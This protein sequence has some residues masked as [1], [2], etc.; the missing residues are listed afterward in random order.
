[1]ARPGL[2]DDQLNI[3]RAAIGKGDSTYRAAEQAGCSESAARKAAKTHGFVKNALKTLVH[4]ELDTIIIE[5]EVKERKSAI[6][7]TKNALSAH[8]RDV[9]DRLFLEE[10]QARNLTFNVA[11]E[12][13]IGLYDMLKSGT[14]D[15][16]VN[17]GDGVQVVEPVR[18][19]PKDY[20]DAAEANDK[21][22]QTQGIVDRPGT[23]VA[24]QQN[25]DG[26]GSGSVVFYLPDNNRE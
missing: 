8:E 16:K 6:K 25:N 11:Q 23:K 21:S 24:V 1:V 12:I 15:E 9:Y 13:Q 18:L 19:S 7:R 10:A 4:E 26:E 2:T 17:K 20:R 5:D 3:I 22:A 14:R